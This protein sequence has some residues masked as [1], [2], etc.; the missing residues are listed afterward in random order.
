MKYTSGTNVLELIWVFNTD[1]YKVT[2]DNDL[3]IFGSSSM[4]GT[5]STYVFMWSL[6]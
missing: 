6:K 2:D 3:R 4:Y 1:W 5:Y